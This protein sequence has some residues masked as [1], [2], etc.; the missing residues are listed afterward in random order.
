MY[1]FFILI[2]QAFYLHVPTRVIRS[3]EVFHIEFH[4]TI[5]VALV[6]LIVFVCWLTIIQIILIYFMTF[7]IR[8]DIALHF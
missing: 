3:F 4:R 6:Q 2:L 5:M 7:C 8:S 1:R